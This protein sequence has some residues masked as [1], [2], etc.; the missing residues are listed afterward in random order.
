MEGEWGVTASGYGDSF[1]GGK[2]ALKLPGSDSC[3]NKKKKRTKCLTVH[4]KQVNFIVCEMYL[5]LLKFF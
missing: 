4:F 3:V 2:C 5:K 1:W